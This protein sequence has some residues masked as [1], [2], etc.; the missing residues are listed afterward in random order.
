MPLF[1]HFFNIYSVIYTIIGANKNKLINQFKNSIK[2]A[3]FSK[4]FPARI[5]H[6][7]CNVNVNTIQCVH[8]H[9]HYK[10]Y[11]ILDFKLHYKEAITMVWYGYAHIMHMHFI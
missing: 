2:F 8:T 7:Q 4:L 3:F 6:S 1:S 5:V 11:Y 10:N 9:I